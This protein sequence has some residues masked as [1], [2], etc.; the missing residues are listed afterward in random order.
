VFFEPDEEHWHGAAPDRLMSHL[1]MVTV[2]DE[3][4]NSNWLEQVTD[5]EY[6]AAAERPAAALS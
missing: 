5:A 2:D 4:N 3:G 6:Q 1:A